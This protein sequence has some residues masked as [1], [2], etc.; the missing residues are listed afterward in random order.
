MTRHKRG[1]AVPLAQPFQMKKFNL[2]RVLICQGAPAQ[3]KEHLDRIKAEGFKIN[4][5]AL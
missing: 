1:I 3:S 2:K 4:Q 5:N